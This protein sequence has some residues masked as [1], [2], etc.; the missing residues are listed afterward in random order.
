MYRSR[1]AT[2]AVVETEAHEGGNERSQAQAFG[3]AIA[4][5]QERLLLPAA[6]LCYAVLSN[7]SVH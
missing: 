6:V 3:Q 7:C 5:V 4:V 2:E 1:G